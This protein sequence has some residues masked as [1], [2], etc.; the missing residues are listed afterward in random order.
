MREFGQI[1]ALGS[2]GHCGSSDGTAGV[3]MNSDINAGAV[4]GA[5]SVKLIPQ[6]GHRLPLRPLTAT[7][8]TGLA[9]IYCR[10]DFFC[11]HHYSETMAIYEY[12]EYVSGDDEYL[13]LL[14]L[15]NCISSTLPPVRRKRG[16][17]LAFL[18]SMRSLRPEDQEY[19]DGCLQNFL[20]NFYDFFWQFFKIKKKK[21]EIRS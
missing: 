13:S 12:S 19:D 17:P 21:K 15:P 9:F 16:R 5:Q 14:H 1:W 18:I 6:L 20:S 8:T 7:E 10:V 4:A 2:R 11:I 3:S